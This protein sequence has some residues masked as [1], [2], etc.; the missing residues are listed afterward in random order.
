MFNFPP[1]VSSTR[2][3]FIHIN[4]KFSHKRFHSHRYLDHRFVTRKT[5]NVQKCGG[6]NVAWKVSTS[7]WIL[8]AHLGCSSPS[9]V[10]SRLC[11][12]LLLQTPS[13]SL[14]RSVLVW[15]G[16]QENPEQYYIENCLDGFCVGWKK[17]H[18]YSFLPF[19]CPSFYRGE[20]MWENSRWQG[21]AIFCQGGQGTKEVLSE[22]KNANRNPWKFS[23]S[24]C[25]DNWKS[26]DSWRPFGQ[27]GRL[28][29]VLCAFNG[30]WFF[31][32]I[33]LYQEIIF[34]GDPKMFRDVTKTSVIN[35][36]N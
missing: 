18:F 23:R 7:L 3:Y 19:K 9:Q 17:A 8:A 28:D 26:R 27:Q 11:R 14:V 10:F 1:T 22:E 35:P 5:D 15:K 33:Q 12:Y 4:V 25:D 20:C 30:H 32:K 36:K 2:E 13:I 31:S 21:G 16:E 6:R 29:F 34:S 24:K